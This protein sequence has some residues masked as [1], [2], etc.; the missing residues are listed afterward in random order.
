MNEKQTENEHSRQIL[1]YKGMNFRFNNNF[2]VKYWVCGKYLTLA[3]NATINVNAGINNEAEMKRARVNAE[4]RDIYIVIRSSGFS[5]ARM[6]KND[7]S[8]S[9]Y[10]AGI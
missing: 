4:I 2:N 10:P 8:V 5:F 1:P 7:I 6:H 9:Y 3:N